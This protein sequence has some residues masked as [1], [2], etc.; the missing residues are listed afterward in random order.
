MKKRLLSVILTSAMAAGMLAGCGSGSTGTS[1][2]ASDTSASTSEA[3]SETTSAAAAVPSDDT[4]YD[5]YIFNGKGEIADSLQAAV[6]A[7]SSENNVKIKLFTL[8]SGV[9]S[10]E[11][12]RTELNSE[13]MP[14]VFTIQDSQYLQEYLEGG[15]AMD[16]SQATNEDFK[17]LAG[18]VSSNQILSRDGSTNYGIPYTVEGYGYIVDKNMLASLFGKD[19]VDAWL[20][21]YKTATYDEFVSMV[22]DCDAY[23][24][25]GSADPVVLSGKSFEFQ[26]KDDLTNQLEGVFAVAGSEKWTCGDHLIN[27]AIDAVFPTALDAA[28]ATADQLD[29]GEPV[30]EKYA[31]LADILT[32]HA[33]TP[34]G[35]ELIEAST[36]SYDMQTQNF[37]NHKAIFVKQGNWAYNGY[38]SANADVKDSLT[39][40]PIKF[41]A[42]D[43]QIKS[44]LTQEDMNTSIPVFVPQYWAI[45]AKCADE[46]KDKAEAFIAWLYTSD[47]GISFVKDQMSMIP[48]NADP[49]TTSAGY[50]LGDSILQYMGEGKTITNAY[51]GCPA[52]WATNTLGQYMLENYVNTAEWPDTAYSDIANYVISSWKEAA[53]L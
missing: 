47:E 2:S 12:L 6:D 36:N 10:T 29:A 39:F 38:V 17:T 11:L 18:Q 20:E 14:T 13:H 50:C 40:I 33:T 46:E 16:V 30:F 42:T 28:N 41:G 52:S 51:A 22:N 19:N 53:G 1:Q 26:P 4:D 44:G 27:I 9:D 35:P 31:E 37:A 32:A 23:I 21:A 48:W 24:K 3:A 25:N 49:S 7:Y 8:G 15:F 5:F 45:N 43:D 34:R